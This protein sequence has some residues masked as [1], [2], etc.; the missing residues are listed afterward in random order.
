MKIKRFWLFA[1]VAML[2]LWPARVFILSQLSAG[3][4]ECKACLAHQI[5]LADIF[6][7][8]AIATVWALS[9]TRI[10]IELRLLLRGVAVLGIWAYA[11]DLVVMKQFGT[12]LMLTDIKIYLADTTIVLNTFT[13]WP[14]LQVLLLAAAVV[15]SLLLW[16][17]PLRK[18][19]GWKAPAWVASIFAMLGVLLHTFSPPSSYIHEW[20]IK[21]VLAA[22]L[23][24]G[25][26][27]EYSQSTVDRLKTAARAQECSKGR[28]IRNNVVLLILESWSTY[29]SQ[30]WLGSNDWTPRLDAL[31][32]QG[33]WFTQLH[34]GGFNTNQGL[35]SLLTGRDIVLPS[36]PPHQMTAFEGA[37]GIQDALPAQLTK[38]GYQTTFLTSGNLG[39]TRK[40]EWLQHI[41]FSETLGHDHVEFE[42]YRRGHF[43]AVADE[44]LYEVALSY[45]IA[46]TKSEAPLFLVIENV[47][48]HHP[49]V[50][51]ITGE[52]KEE[53]V[54]RYMDHA[55]ADFI[56]RLQ[57]NRFLDNGL[58]VVMSDH[59]AMTF[60][61]PEEQQRFGRSAASR[62]PGFILGG[63]IQRSKSVDEPM[64]QADLQPSLLRQISDTYCAGQRLRDLLVPEETQARCLFHARGDNR[65]H[66][67]VYCAEGEGVVQVNGD[68]SR[69]ISS[70]NL[71][72]AKQLFIL[73]EIAGQRLGF[74]P[75]ATHQFDSSALPIH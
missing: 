35:V 51:P 8:G 48:S 5:I 6:Y 19:L 37:W 2:A 34:A 7:W 68:D 32:T 23:P 21:N 59:R 11:I 10:S 4:L 56:E 50:H 47:S 44:R 18:P 29:H 26:S 25:V 16:I 62:I 39:Y 54:F 61:T 67:D 3:I 24:T 20:A 49:F 71:S 43:D 17:E 27:N 1:V 69:F 31:A 12:R 58:I 45:I 57:E 14:T 55:A 53:S 46:Q 63:N 74:L 33:L 41:G 40:G 64:H 60:I 65:D 70:K 42:G 13:Q 52:R 30:Q 73:D 38:L 9:L 75:A 22:N 72:P 15:I 36:L 66:V 28:G